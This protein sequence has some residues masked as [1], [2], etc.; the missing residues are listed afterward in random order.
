MIADRP[1]QTRDG[2]RIGGAQICAPPGNEPRVYECR[3]CR[4]VGTAAVYDPATERPSGTRAMCRTCDG[5]GY[6]FGAGASG[7]RIKVSAPKL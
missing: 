1:W 3:T 7:G 5:R 2:A 4:G 6:T